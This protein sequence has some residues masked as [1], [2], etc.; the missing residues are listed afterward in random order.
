[1]TVAP[2][3]T[4]V[5]KRVEIG[6]LRGGLRVIRSGLAPNDRVIIDGHSA[7]GTR[8]KSRAT[9]RHDPLRRGRR[10]RLGP[11]P[12]HAPDTFLHRSALLRNRAQHLRDAAWSGRARDPAGRPISGNRPADGTG[13]DILSRRIRRDRRPHRRNAARTGD[14]RRRE[15]A[16]HEQPVDRRRQAHHYR[17]VPRSAPT[18]TSRRC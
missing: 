5:P 6:D 2:D 4:V 11:S 14:Q 16:L 3:G 15:H 17:H 7:R 9:G 12:R 1:M 10:P 8:S 18:S 13:H